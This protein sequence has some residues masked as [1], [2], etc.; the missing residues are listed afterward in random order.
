MNANDDE[1]PALVRSTFMRV[2]RTITSGKKPHKQCVN[3]CLIVLLFENMRNVEYIV[4]KP[5]TDVV[6]IK[7]LNKLGMRRIS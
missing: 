4:G 5:V 2:I 6:K 7:K 3:F 1:V